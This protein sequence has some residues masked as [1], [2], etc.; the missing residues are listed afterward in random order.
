MA[1]S[2]PHAVD[3]LL[4]GLGRELDR[5]SPLPLY[6][7]I[8]E[9]LRERIERGEL[10][11][12]ER[13]PSEN[14][15]ERALGVSRMTARRALAELETE[16][17]VYREQGRGTFVAEPKLRQSLLRL[18]SFTEDMRARGLRPGARVLDVR[19]M[20]DERVAA[21]MGL[22]PEEAF[23][24]VRRVRLAD[25]QPLA[26]ET[27]YVRAALCPGLEAED[28]TD[29]SLYQTLR[30]RYKLQLGRAEQTLE[31]GAATE[32]EAQVLRIP[33]GQPVLLIERLTF[34]GDGK[35]PIE[36]V[37]SVYRG[38]RYKFVVELRR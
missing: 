14:E 31:A 32:F 28:L 37:R 9:L 12:H 1:A 18:T 23:V 6:Y 20:R 22:E 15:L 17:Y 3:A 21:R 29:R 2:H 13:L 10:R 19:V 34:L 36:F 8:K 4:E 5:A 7:Q 26:L 11:P 33:V 30:E 38:D 35:T 27:A 24:R 25:G 16:G